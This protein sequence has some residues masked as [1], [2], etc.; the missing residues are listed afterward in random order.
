MNRVVQLSCFGRG[1]LLL[2][3]G[4]VLAACGS[5]AQKAAP[6]P[7]P[8][9]VVEKASL[10]DLTAASE[11]TG[12]IEAIDKVQV[13]AR[14]QGFIKSR[15]FEEGA[16]VAK[17]DLLFE[18]E[19]DS[20][21]ISV[22]Q[23][24]AAL[25][26]A[27]AALTLAQQTFDRTE[28]LA[29]RNVS[30]QASLD[31]ARSQLAQALANVQAQEAALQT[32]QLNLSYTKITSAIG[33]RAGRATYSVG[34]F[35]GPDSGELVVVV[36]QDPMYVSF[37]VPQRVLLAVRKAGEGPDSVTVQLRLAD[38]TLYDQVGQIQFVGVQASSSTDSVLVRATIPNPQQLLVDQ[39]LVRV[40]VVNKKPEQKLVVSQAALVLD[41]RGAYV[42]AV[43]DQDK[44]AIK[45]VETGEQHGPLIVMTSGLNEGDRVII[46]GH[47]KV[48]PG[49][50]V[51][52]TEANA[53][54]GLSREPATK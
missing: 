3:V 14:V 36:A 21:A 38:G 49:S 48:Q 7:P 15:A 24:E 39:Q 30:S 40:R 26:N 12:R 43:D 17:G 45:R 42:L 31:T 35:V 4:L 27:K 46:S 29:E 23:S 33:G 5:E 44:V 11:F 41:Q 32:A 54:E 22:T 9:V 34:N 47:Q 18:I 52:P 8:T 20:Y 53:A 10:K 37:P 50:T 1:G 51:Q 28:D 19:P 2:A 16:D 6:A 25:A 13:R